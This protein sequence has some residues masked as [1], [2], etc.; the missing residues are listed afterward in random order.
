MTR[1]MWRVSEYV[2]CVANC[3]TLLSPAFKRFHEKLPNLREM[4]YIYPTP[5]KNMCDELGRHIYIC[6][7]LHMYQY[8][9]ISEH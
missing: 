2:A 7:V 5:A 1:N 8:K 6:F 3:A 4:S 9:L